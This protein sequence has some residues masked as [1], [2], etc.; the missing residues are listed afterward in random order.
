MKV[1]DPSNRD[2]SSGLDI[3]RE[4]IAGS[5][6]DIPFWCENMLF[7]LADPNTGVA[8]WLHLG[9]TPNDWTLW[10]DMCYA[11]MPND[12]GILSMWSYHRTAPDRQ[13]GGAN[14]R[15][16]CIEPFRRW[17]VQMDGYGLH[18]PLDEMTTGLAR[19]GHKK[20]FHVDLDVEFLTPV[21]DMHTAATDDTGQG[22]MHDQNWAK[23]HYEQQ[24]HATGTVV[25]GDHELPFDGF[26]WR[27]HSQGPRG[28]TNGAPWGGHTIIGGIYPESGRGWG[29]G[30]Y[31]EPSGRISLE[32]GYVVEEDGAL[33]HA[34]VTES[35]RLP[36]LTLDSEQLDIGLKWPGGSL[37]T[38]ITTKTSMWLAMAQALVVGT[39]LSGPGLMY[40]LNHGTASWDGEVGQI[41]VERSDP[42]NEFPTL[43]H[44]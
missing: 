42:I 5:E 28:G 31:W 4:Q 41:Y 9:T 14:T 7:A 21:W 1:F 13:P 32:G 27:D 33:I 8:L 29:L 3:G 25:L 22:T 44:D 17:H 39:D 10:Q 12:D 37:E 24:Y 23:E 35:P 38:T 36:S 11:V 43:H 16:E 34:E 30:R 26:G 20:R 19:E 18:T 40:V 6:P 15:F 2:L